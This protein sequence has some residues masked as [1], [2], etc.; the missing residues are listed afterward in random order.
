MKKKLL[1]GLAMVVAVCTIGACGAKEATKPTDT[2]TNETETNKD[3]EVTEETKATEAPEMTSEEAITTD[4]AGN[5]IT[6]PTSI[7][8]VMIAGPSNAEILEGLGMA[9]KI[10]AADNY[11]Q[12]L[13]GL[14]SD[15][16]F[17]DMAA[18]DLEQMLALQADIFLVTGMVQ[19][20]DDNV[21]QQLIDSG[22]CVIFI[23]SSNSLAGIEEDIQYIADVMGASDKGLAIVATMQ[24]K[25]AEI[26]AIGEGISDKKS[27]YFELAAAPAMYSFGNG[28]FLNEMIELVGATNIFVDQESWLAVTEESILEANPDVIL[29]SVNYIDNPID[30]IKG[31]SGWDVITAVRDDAVYSIDTNA[32]N[33]PSQNI[34]K[35]LEEMAKAVY[36]EQYN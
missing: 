13:N 27:V 23:P 9:D 3:A 34:V 21:Y 25:I 14:G 32:S 11:S 2:A 24:S 36:P 33:N 8:K 15:V 4:R 6:L 35:A 31:R 1:L 18:P 26:K 28:V 10:V 16:M 12:G 30:E 19:A 17:F 29:S 7:E 20:G 22:V 5:T